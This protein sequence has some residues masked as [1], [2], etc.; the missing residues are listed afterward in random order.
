MHPHDPR[1]IY[2][3]Q[4]FEGA[5]ASDL[6]LAVYGHAIQGCQSGR[7]KVVIRAL[8]ELIGGLDLERGDL[9]LGLLRM[10]EYLLYRAREGELQEVGNSLRELRTAWEASLSSPSGPALH[11]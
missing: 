8:E 6:V 3:Q 7:R 9:A 1:R 11:P 2:R 4:Q 5:T 10:Y